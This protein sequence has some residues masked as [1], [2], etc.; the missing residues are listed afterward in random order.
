MFP[1]W[2][3]GSRRPWKDGTSAR[4]AA[5]TAR[6]RD[7][8][9]RGPAA[10]PPRALANHSAG[11]FSTAIRGHAI[12]IGR[13]M[14]RLGI[15]RSRGSALTLRQ[16]LSS[17]CNYCADTCAREAGTGPRARTTDARGGPLEI[18]RQ[19]GSTLGPLCGP[20]FPPI[21]PDRGPNGDNDAASSVRQVASS[22]P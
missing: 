17:I 7:R 22:V 16:G 6:V 9:G 2:K 10:G 20:G 15:A 5:Y 12:A 1:S 8:R 3:G 18:R 4:S 11:S 19:H 21:G 13:K 14:S